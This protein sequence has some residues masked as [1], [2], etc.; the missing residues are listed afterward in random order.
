MGRPGGSYA[1]L[2]HFPDDWKTRSVIKADFVLCIEAFGT[3]CP[4]ENSYYRP[5]SKE[6]HEWAVKLHNMYQTCLEMGQIKPHPL[7]VVGNTFES[8][9]DGLDLLKTGAVSGKRL[10][11]V[12]PEGDSVATN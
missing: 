7:E 10:A 3:E 11:V 12:F 2:E 6:K 5:K 1:G 8:I 9:L 4:V